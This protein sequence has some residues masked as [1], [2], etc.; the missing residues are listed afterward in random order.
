[1]Q[2]DLRSGEERVADKASK[3]TAMCSPAQIS[4]TAQAGGS[5]AEGHASLDASKQTSARQE[6]E[7]SAAGNEVAAVAA[8]LEGSKD[9]P[10]TA[11]LVVHHV[12]LLDKSVSCSCMLSAC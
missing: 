2:I 6:M 4:V 5:V 11:S 8:D 12:A 7:G 9:P 3:L 10:Q 1:M